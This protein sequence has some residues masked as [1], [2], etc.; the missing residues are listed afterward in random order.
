VAPLL[1]VVWLGIVL[2]VS[3]MLFS[4]AGALFDRRRENLAM[5]V[6]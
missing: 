3:R 6:S 4:A 1:L 2:V 5:L